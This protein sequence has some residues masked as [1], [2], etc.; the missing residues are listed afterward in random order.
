MRAILNHHGGSM[1]SNIAFI[2]FIL[3]FLVLPLSAGGGAEEKELF[4]LYPRSVSSIAFFELVEKYPEDYRGEVFTDHAQSLA[5]LI[6]GEANVLVTGFTLGQNRFVST[7]DVVHLSTYVWGVSSIIVRNRIESFEDIQTIMVPFEG[8]PI[9]LQIKA[10]IELL[11]LEDDIKIL[12]APFPQAAAQL[13][14]DKI[15]AAVL[16]E[17]IASNIEATPAAKRLL[18]IQEVYE[19]IS[20]IQESP[21]VSLFSSTEGSKKYQREFDTLISRLGDI[22]DEI[23]DN[24]S[25]YAEKYAGFFELD[26]AIL[27]KAITSSYFALPSDEDIRRFIE[28]YTYTLKQPELSEDFYY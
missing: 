27:E 1:K 9:D 19:E 8:S 23:T 5:R 7:G 16:V 24:P 18:T 10:Y 15:D 14:Q 12:Y 26:A 3:C 4:I 17:P 22:L 28:K 11:G 21:Q 25:L 6:S 2:F 20:G 13:M